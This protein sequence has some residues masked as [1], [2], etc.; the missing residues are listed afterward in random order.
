MNGL[1]RRLLLSVLAVAALGAGGAVPARA[2]AAAAGRELVASIGAGVIALITD[3]RLDDHGREKR[4]RAIYR[5]HFDN[6]AIAAWVLGPAWRRANDRERAEFA[7]LFEGY[8]V[9]AVAARLAGYPAER[10]L[11]L[12][13]ELDGAV[14][15]VTTHLV[16]PNPRASRNIEMRWRLVQA[17]G[18]LKVVD[19]TVDKIGIAATLRRDISRMLDGAGGTLRGLL[20]TLRQQLAAGGR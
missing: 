19:V 11:V 14:V 16:D 2:D 5:E 18:R 4:F 1:R 7:Q 13:S 12:K 10:L 17:G 9:R 6:R 20:A 3:S 8:V 15:I